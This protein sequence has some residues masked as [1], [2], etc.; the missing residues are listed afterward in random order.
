[1]IIDEYVSLRVPPTAGRSNLAFK[2]DRRGSP[3]AASR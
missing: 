2:K 1:M 3:A